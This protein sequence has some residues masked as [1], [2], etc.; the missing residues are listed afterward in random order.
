MYSSY[1]SDGLMPRDTY[2]DWCMPPEEL[3]MIHSRDPGRITPGTLLGTCFFYHDLRLMQGFAGRLSRPVDAA[4]FDSLATNMKKAYNNAFFAG[5]GSYY[6]NNTVT[7]NL[8][9]LAFGLVPDEKKEAVFNNAVRQIETEYHGHI[10]VGLIGIMVLQRT[11]TDL[12]RPDIAMRFA[13]ETTYPG[14]GYMVENGATTIWELWNGNTADPS[15]NS[16]NHVMLLGD[17]IIWLHEYVAGI[18]PAEPGFKSIVMKPLVSQGLHFV[19]ATHHSPY[20]EIM[21]NWTMDGKG[22]FSFNIR[23]PFNTKARVFVPAN[24]ASSV[25]ES[26]RKASRSAGV[27]AAGFEEGYA[28]FDIGSGEYH[29]TSPA[30]KIP[31]NPDICSPSVDIRPKDQSTPDLLTVNLSTTDPDA[32]IRYTLDGSEP[33]GNSARYDKPLDLTSSCT[34][35]ARSYKKSMAPGYV[36]SRTYDIYDPVK[37]GLN[38]SY[39]RGK[40]DSIPDFSAL[41]PVK[42][43]R[44]SGFPLNDIK[45]AEDYWGIRFTGFIT[46]PR[47]GTYAFTTLSDDGSRLFINHTLV[48]NN[49]GIHGPFT[50]KGTIDLKK[51]KYPLMLDY[52]EGNYGEMLRVGIEGPGMTSRQ[53]PVSMLTFE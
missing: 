45:S 2:G 52:F 46:I 51:G 7:A 49:D 20:G 39:Y 37:N 43:G 10:P 24:D 21:S 50:V 27:K 32:V 15:M 14:W 17:L 25:R 41:K 19:R 40:W 33:T 22:D 3:T 48:V 47:D 29:F 38:Y 9:S 1:G 30:V 36:T 53:L 12:G 13:R 11:L 42:K 4:L 34:V 8:L 31:E 44:V 35:Q 6:G 5:Q 28:I 23:V 16:G 18:R 26:G